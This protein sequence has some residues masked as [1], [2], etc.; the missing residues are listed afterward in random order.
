MI[1][2]L[3]PFRERTFAEIVEQLEVLLSQSRPAFLLG[4]GCSTCAGLPLMTDLTKDVLVSTTL[5]SNSKNILQT[6]VQHFDGA[7]TATIEDYLSELVDWLSVAERRKECASKQATVTLEGK[8]Y[9]VD[10]LRRAID[11]IKQAIALRISKSISISTHS[12]FVRAVHKTLQFGKLDS[13]LPVDYF[14]LNYDTVIEDALG[15]NR[16]PYSDGFCGGATGWWDIT[17][18]QKNGLAAR[19]FKVHG[20][21]DWCLIDHDVLPRRLR[22]D[23]KISNSCEKVMIWP[24]TTKY[25]ETQHDPFAQILEV[26]RRRLRPETNGE[27]VLVVCGYSFGDAHINLELARAL[28]ESSGRL[29]VVVLTDANEPTG[30][31]AGW[32]KDANINSQL[33]VY[34]KRGFFHADAKVVSTVDLPWWK[35]EV[36]T[37]LLG[38]ER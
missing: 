16:I 24:A 34:A 15:L 14:L 28:T 31:V 13:S 23:I 37:R 36:F 20:S 2:E 7:T 19:V 32:L 30:V 1:D 22:P 8:A 6:I 25:R 29:T 18:Y 38:G 11:D 4:A 17:D 5:D 27:L 9:T 26:M 10:A 35:F 21:V 3:A 33:R 12:Q